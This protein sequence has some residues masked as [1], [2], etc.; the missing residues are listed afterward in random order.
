M[1]MALG[2][3]ALALAAVAGAPDGGRGGVQI[4]YNVRIVEAE[5]IEWRQ[6]VMTRM[7][8]VTRQGA[9]TVWTAPRDVE[10][11]LLRSDRIS[12]QGGMNASNIVASSGSPIHIRTRDDRQIVTQAA[13]NGEGGSI[14]TRPERLGVGSATTM[15]G[16]KLDQGILVQVVFKD[17][18]V[19][20]V[21]R[22]SVD[23]PKTHSASSDP[24]TKAASYALACAGVSNCQ[25]DEGKSSTADVGSSKE[26]APM[27]TQYPWSDLAAQPGS[28][29]AVRPGIPNV[30]QKRI[31]LGKKAAKLN[32]KLAK[33]RGVEF[34]VVEASAPTPAA[35]CPEATDSA[36]CCA[37]EAQKV[38]IEVP[39]IDS[40]EIAGEWLIPN[41]G[42]LLVSFG[43]HTMAGKDGK[44]VIRERLA[45]IMA[46]ESPA[47]P[48]YY[49]RPMAVSAAAAWPKPEAPST[50]I[51]TPMPVPAAPAPPMPSRSIPQ[52]YH[53]DGKAAELPPLPAEEADDDDDSSEARPSPQT[54]KPRPTDPEPAVKPEAKPKPKPSG[55]TAARKAQFS[56]EEIPAIPAMFRSAPSIGLQFLLPIKP[57]KVR[58]PFDRRLEI[59]IYGRIVPGPQPDR[60]AAELATKGPKDGA[61][62]K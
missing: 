52:G 29:P 12:K 17:S 28:D 41:D 16:R 23:G 44:A 13:W 10:K 37:A 56:I 4:K 55:D 26:P 57:V 35:E 24:A 48:S 21:H 31:P 22:V 27:Q 1:G 40:Q 11:A 46:E 7:T 45:I 38:A 9:A 49:V 50:S 14:A 42:I 34:M 5:G 32:R 15:T 53:K 3:M 51:P 19:V 18:K 61:T 59:V 60:S 47:P 36:C 30:N 43:P 20:A 2:W 25:E 58:L 33:K 8:P 54:R 62:T 39:E 6:G